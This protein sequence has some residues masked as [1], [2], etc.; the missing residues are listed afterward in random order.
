MRLYFLRHGQADWPNWDKSDDERPLNKKGIKETHRVAKFLRKLEVK[1]GL[2]ISSPLPRA[3]QTAQIAA[4]AL[5]VPLVEEV[6]LSPCSTPEKLHA[7][8]QKY[9]ENSTMVVGHEPDFSNMLAALTG[10]QLKLAK[11]GVARVDL[12]AGEEGMEE[13]PEKWRGR[14][15]WLIAPK[16]IKAMDV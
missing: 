11:S 16:A 5:K 15:V 14:L 2:I 6:G 4:K 10:A 3:T 7:I 8:V 12:E 1:P 9:E 13:C